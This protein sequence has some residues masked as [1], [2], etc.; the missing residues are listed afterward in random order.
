MLGFD[1]RGH[2]V[3]SRQAARATFVAYTADVTFPLSVKLRES[4]PINKM[5]FDLARFPLCFPR[6]A[7]LN[8]NC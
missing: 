5:L 8:C 7:A 1:V 4:Q 2:Y 6:I 3:Y